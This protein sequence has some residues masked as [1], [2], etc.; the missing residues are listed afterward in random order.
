MDTKLF[1]RNIPGGLFIVTDRTQVPSGTIWWVGSTVTGASD[2]AG[3]GTS[4]DSPFATLDYAIGKCT[5]SVGDVIYLLPG[6]AE[7][8]A[9]ATSAAVDVAGISIIGL[10]SGALQPTFTL[11]TADTATIAVSAANVTIENIKVTSGLADVAAGITTTNSADGLTIKNCQFT[12]PTADMELLIGISLATG[13]DNVTIANNRFYAATTNDSLSAVK[14]VGAC[15]NLQ[16]IGNIA[17]GNYEAAVF[18]LD[19]AANTNAIILRNVL[20]NL[21][22]TTGL[23]ISC[24]ASGTGLI[25]DNRA[26]GVKNNT[27]TIVAAGTLNFENYGTDTAG[28]TGIL[29]PSTAT[30]WS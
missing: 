7:S 10:G 22:A 15:D 29:T 9:A 13:T 24:H 12:A 5:A 17:Y 2:A 3:F 23:V 30:A 8:L 21:D 6:H 20:G 28:T 26:G 25:A 11:G 19:A 18:D 1:A 14:T 16:L 4:P 27:E